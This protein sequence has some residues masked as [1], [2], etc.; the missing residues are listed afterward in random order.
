VLGVP[1]HATQ[2][3]SQGTSG[4]QLPLRATPLPERALP[5]PSVALL[6]VH[7]QQIAEIEV[8]VHQSGEHWFCF[9]GLWRP[10]PDDAGDAFTLLTTDPG[11]DVAP[12]HD[13]QMVVLD[14]SDWLAWLD[15]T[16]PEAE[17]VRPLPAGSFTTIAQI[18]WRA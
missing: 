12:I 1:A 18:R 7:R 9:A 14:R 15:L 17:L 11:P 13:R 4:H 2:G 5:H 10:M 8:D 3:T 16:R 6:W